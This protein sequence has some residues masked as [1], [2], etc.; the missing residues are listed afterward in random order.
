[1]K[2]PENGSQRYVDEWKLLRMC[3]LKK[4][5]KRGIQTAMTDNLWS[6]YHF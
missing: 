3:D 1:M 4:F 5:L 2:H 6:L